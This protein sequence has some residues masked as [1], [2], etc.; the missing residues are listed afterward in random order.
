MDE[1]LQK[2]IR[3]KTQ[4][5]MLRENL[6]QAEFAKRISLSRSALNAWLN[7]H[8]NL[9][10]RSFRE[11]VKLVKPQETLPPKVEL[12]VELLE[13]IISRIHEIQHELKVT[14]NAIGMNQMA[15]PNFRYKYR[16]GDFEAEL[17]FPLYCAPQ[18]EV[19]EFMRVFFSSLKRDFEEKE[20][21][22]E[23][24]DKK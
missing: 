19:D 1:N 10:P 13:Q 12:T 21:S 23:K 15:A 5:F 8:G 2:E 17:E 6:T 4:E 11:V 14:S 3:Q 20:K 16:L 9:H 24:D 18:N 7:K 22:I